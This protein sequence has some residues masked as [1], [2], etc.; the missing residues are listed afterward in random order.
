MNQKAYWQSK[1]IGKIKKC[2]SDLKVLAI[3]LANFI[4]HSNKVT[5][6]DRAPKIMIL[7]F[8]TFFSPS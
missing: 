3:Y 5:I 7:T 8:L 2:I 1:G 4:I 6:F